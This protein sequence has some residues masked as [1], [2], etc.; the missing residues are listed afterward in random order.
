[1][2]TANEQLKEAIKAAEAAAAKVEELKKLSREQDLKT[3]KE[4]IKDHGFTITDLKPELK[5][6]AV[7]GT[8]TPRKSSRRK[9]K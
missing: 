8:S 5:T 3:A 7:R 4:L 9:S 2:A 1:M 6:R